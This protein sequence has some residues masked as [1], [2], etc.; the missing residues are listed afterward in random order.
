MFCKNCGTQLND[1]ARFCPN[2][3]SSTA[4]AAPAAAPVY[5]QP[6]APKGPSIH[7]DRYAM[8]TWKILY[9]VAAG[10]LLLSLIFF[11]VDNISFSE[12]GVD[13]SYDL[14]GLLE[15]EATVT[16]EGYGMEEESTGRLVEWLALEG[17]GNLTVLMCIASVIIA[18]LPFIPMLKFKFDSRKLLMIKI[19]TI[20]NLA[21]MVLGLIF[22]NIEMEG[23]ILNMPSF[24]GW[25]FILLTVGS[26]VLSIMVSGAMKK[27]AA[28]APAQPVYYPAQ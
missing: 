28:P 10:L 22:V 17:W 21:W 8:P 1:D 19:S 6:K 24:A 27:N 7:G 5:A 16:V 3:G 13:A 20:W 14:P 11:Y 4:P 18:G 15:G 12:F 23:E 2:C 26:L 9:I 25:I